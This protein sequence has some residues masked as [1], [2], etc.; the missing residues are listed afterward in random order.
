M[1]GIGNRLFDPYG[2][3]TRAMVVKILYNAEGMPE[4]GGNNPFADVEAGKWYEEPVKW[5]L[6][7][8]ITTG[9]SPAEFSP[10][11]S[12]TRQE[13]ASFLCRYARYKGYDTSQRK[14]LSAYP[15]QDKISAYAR[16]AMA[17][18]NAAGILTGKG[19]IYLDPQGTAARAEIAAMVQRF[20]AYYH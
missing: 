14:D 16:E 11:R 1:Q 15:D 7:N 10:N 12:V 2:M 9:T 3:T 17:W 20:E 19:G 13:V 5:A 6:E 18:A 4:A 8:G